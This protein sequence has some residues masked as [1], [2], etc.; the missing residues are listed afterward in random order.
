MKYQCTI[1]DTNK[2][3]KKQNK[4]YCNNCKKYI[5]ENEVIKIVDLSKNAK[6]GQY[7]CIKCGSSEIIY[8]NKLKS[9][10][11]KYCG[12]LFK[13]ETSDGNKIKKL[14][15]NT[16]GKASLNIDENFNNMVAIKCEGCGSEVIIDAHDK[17]VARCQWCRSILSLNDITESGLIPDKILPFKLTKEEALKN[18][19]EYIQGGDTGYFVNEKFKQEL[20]LD[21]VIGVY[22]PY[23]IIDVNAHSKLKGKGKH[24][25]GYKKSSKK[26]S[27]SV[28]TYDIEREFDLYIDDISLESNSNRKDIN[29][30]ERANNIINAVMPFDTE[31]ALKYTGNYLIGYNAEKRDLNQDDLN[32]DLKD[33]VV[34]I[35][36]ETLRKDNNFYNGGISWN[37]VN[38]EVIGTK[39]LS[40]YLPIWLYSYQEDTKDSKVLHYVAVNARTGKTMASI[41]INDKRAK[42]NFYVSLLVFGCILA[43]FIIGA[44]FILPILLAWLFSMFQTAFD[45]NLIVVLLFVLT[46]IL[47][48][49]GLA[50]SISKLYKW[51]NSHLR[52][53]LRNKDAKYDYKRN[54]KKSFANIIKKD[55][56]IDTSKELL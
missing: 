27:Y 4:Y 40:I 16:S 50:F 10:E 43:P 56:K 37:E 1:C 38:T 49:I 33:K 13:E 11:C 32:K 17:P 53:N 9:L 45:N 20:T 22:M 54:T 46:I 36:Q 12:C 47:M 31:K 2:V 7:S 30:D 15:G 3:V 8:N 23:M 55:T 51:H 25:I 52:N 39:W 26:K 35:S 42:N 6:N 14:R 28:E 44:F 5:E 21:N 34:N 19:K 48:I 24:I 41:P 18:L 29:N